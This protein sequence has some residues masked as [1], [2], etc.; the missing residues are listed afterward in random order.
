MALPQ[1]ANLSREAESSEISQLKGIW[2]CH[3]Q[4]SPEN[5]RKRSWPC[6]R[7]KH[8]WPWKLLSEGTWP[9]SLEPLDCQQAHDAP[10]C[11][12]QRLP[13]GQAPGLTPLISALWEA[14]AD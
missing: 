14:K 10:W 6:L 3:E 7:E 11:H 4:P 13:A 9:Y 5:L 1:G 8:G 2:L 12:I